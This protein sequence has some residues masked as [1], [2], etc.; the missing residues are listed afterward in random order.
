MNFK[1]YRTY[2]FSLLF[3]ANCFAFSNTETASNNSALAST[4]VLNT[5]AAGRN[6]LSTIRSDKDLLEVVRSANQEVYSSLQ[7][8]VCDEE[9]RR[10]KGRIT[11]ESRRLID[12]VTA[13]VSFENG[14]EEYTAIRQNDRG[15]PSLSSLAGAWSTGEFGTLLQQ[16]RQLLKTDSVIFRQYTDLNGVSAAVYGIETGEQDSPWDLQIGARHYRIP[17]RTEVW[18]ARDSGEIMKITRVS[19]AM[20]AG[21]GISEIHWGVTLS[22]VE[23]SGKTWLLPKTADYAVMYEGAGRR[24]WNEMVF[25]NYRHYGSEVALRFH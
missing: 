17:F 11:G 16:T 10:F 2:C 25:A 7:S 3:V 14:V 9:I 18:V 4:P 20:P 1:T 24:E 23:L 13:K 22:A 15:L 19:T 12:R 5:A 8:F 6:T 21:M